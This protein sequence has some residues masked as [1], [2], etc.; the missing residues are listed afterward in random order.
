[1]KTRTENYEK[2][3]ECHFNTFLK[4]HENELKK[5][6]NTLTQKVQEHFFLLFKNI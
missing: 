6:L 1:M 5:N 4:A 2:I 3:K